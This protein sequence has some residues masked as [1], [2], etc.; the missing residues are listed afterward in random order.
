VRAGDVVL[1]CGAGI[2]LFARQA[3]KRGART[4]IA[5]EPVPENLECLRR[6]LSR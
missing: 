2:G 1:D 3:L 6:N 4:V 5:I